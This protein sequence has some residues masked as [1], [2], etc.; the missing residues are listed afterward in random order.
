M[1][2][3]SGSGN[4]SGSGSGNVSGSAY[5]GGPAR[6]IP[7]SSIMPSVLGAMQPSSYLQTEN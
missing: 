3:E 4:V 2:G 5:D 7:T 1:D 6:S